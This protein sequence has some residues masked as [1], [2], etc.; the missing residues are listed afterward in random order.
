MLALL[1]C[2]RKT[3]IKKSLYLPVAMLANVCDA[4]MHKIVQ[5]RQDREQEKSTTGR[6]KQERGR[7]CRM[8][9]ARV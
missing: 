6:G 8:C 7:T 4:N 9:G 1:R 2:I 3:A 5:R